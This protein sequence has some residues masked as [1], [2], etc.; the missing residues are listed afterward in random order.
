MSQ[1]YSDP[2]RRADQLMP[3]GVP[4]W[5]RCY[6]NGGETADRFTVIFSGRYKGRTGGEG[7]YLGASADPFAPQG[8][9]LTGFWRANEAPPD[10]TG[11]SWGGPSIGRR[12]HLGL[13]VGF[14]DLP[15]DVQRAALDIYRTLWNLEPVR[16]YHTQSM[17][18]KL[19]DARQHNEE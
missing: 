11:N 7:V 16:T 1:H 13:R 18:A 3:A 5:A 14:Q 19:A 6:D 10:V 12:C 2:S 9:G 8:V 17:L 4:K 15:A